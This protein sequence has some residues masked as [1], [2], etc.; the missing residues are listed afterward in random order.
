MICTNY[1][2]LGLPT[3]DK[4]AVLLVLF[5]LSP[6]P[7]PMFTHYLF[8]LGFCKAD[9]VDCLLGRPWQGQFRG[10]E[11][12]CR[13]APT[14]FPSCGVLAVAAF[15]YSISSFLRVPLPVVN[16]CWVIATLFSLCP[17]MPGMRAFPLQSLPEPACF[18]LTHGFP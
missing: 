14:P 1:F 4:T 8:C 7:L 12:H 6:N 9:P 17:F 3:C 15:L 11:G 16:P 2:A 10:E 18:T 5:V 13:I